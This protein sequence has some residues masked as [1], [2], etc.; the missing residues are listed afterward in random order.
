M[1]MIKYLLYVVLTVVI[2]SSNVQADSGQ[3]I[4]TLAVYHEADG[5]LTKSSKNNA[6]TMRRIAAKRGYITLW[7]TANVDFDPNIDDL[8]E[9]ERVS[10][11]RAAT[12]KLMDVLQPLVDADKV[13]HPSAG[14]YI[15]GPGCIIRATAAGVSRLVRDSRILHMVAQQ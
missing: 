10:Q 3:Q 13:W 6:A 8:S 5:K 11:Q 1:K 9:A 4:A 12:E 7:V 2:L 14:P 15:Q